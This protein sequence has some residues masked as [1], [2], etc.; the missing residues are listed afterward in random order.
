MTSTKTEILS[1]KTSKAWRDWL[2]LHHA[3]SPSICLQIDKISAPEQTI[4]YKEALD[5]ALC[6]GWIDGQKLPYKN[7]N[8]VKV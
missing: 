3:S 4:S 8:A 6:F 2:E 5:E 1:F 7:F